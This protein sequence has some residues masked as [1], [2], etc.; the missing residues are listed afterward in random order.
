[1]GNNLVPCDEERI[2]KG[3]DFEQYE[4]ERFF[5]LN[6]KLGLGRGEETSSIIQ[7]DNRYFMIIRY[8]GSDVNWKYTQPCEVERIE[9]EVRYSVV[10]YKPIDLENKNRNNKNHSILELPEKYKR[11]FIHG[12]TFDY[13]EL[14]ELVCAYSIAD[15]IGE[16]S[17]WDV[18]MTSIIPVDGRLFAIDWYQGL[19]ENQENEYNSQPYEVKR[20][21]RVGTILTVEYIPI[22]EQQHELSKLW[23]SI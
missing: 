19:A 9:Q 1:M 20:R 7:I 3:Y 21:E 17:Q 22:K 8:H 11:K 12:D 6:R 18:Q 4:L 5:F 13:D 2:L 16:Q 14:S 23:R 10:K 15:I